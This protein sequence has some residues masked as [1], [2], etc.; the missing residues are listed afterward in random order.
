LVGQD[1]KTIKENYKRSKIKE[2]EQNKMCQKEKE[3]GKI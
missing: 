1:E 2:N 3:T